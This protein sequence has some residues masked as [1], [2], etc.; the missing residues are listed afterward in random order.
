MSEPAAKRA[1]VDD[2]TPQQRPP[3]TP[4]RYD[5]LRDLPAPERSAAINACQK[6]TDQQ[7]EVVKQV[8]RSEA[9]RA[10][11]TGGRIALILAAAAA[12]KTTTLFA[13]IEA[14]ARFGHGRSYGGYTLYCCFN[15]AAA[16]DGEMKLGNLSDAAQHSC[17]CR[18]LHSAILK[19]HPDLLRNVKFFPNQRGC[20]WDATCT[21]WTQE[22]CEKYVLQTCADEI[23][24]FILGPNARPPTTA[25][26][27]K[28]LK[29]E[30]EL[31]AFWIYK[32][33]GEF[34]RK[35]GG[36]DILS[37]TNV[38]HRGVGRLAYYPIIKNMERSDSE[39]RLE[40]CPRGRTHTPRLAGHDAASC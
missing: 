3:A 21:S 31:V 25:K 39:R 24:Q 9:I 33:L 26:E 17:V 8:R 22:Q 7:L 4:D 20:E 30:E 32:T 38:D 2:N 14:L 12:G 27:L 36:R 28:K 11:P 18:T 19:T 16:A 29:R 1:R 35:R 40:V 6:L 13:L 10:S 5:F 15:K 23:R 34:L 37:P